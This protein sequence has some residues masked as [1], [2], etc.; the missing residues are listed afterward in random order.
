[1]TRMA[2]AIGSSDSFIQA[3]FLDQPLRLLYRLR[4]GLGLVVL[5]GSIL[6]LL[7]G[8][9][10]IEW[11]TLIGRD[12]TL[13]P[14]HQLMLLG[15]ALSGIAAL[16]SVLIETV[17][18]RRSQEI[19]AN[20][21]SFANFFYAPL[22][23]YLAGFA[24]LSAGI[25]FTLDSYWHALYGIDVAIWAPFHI[26]L[27]GGSGM[28]S[29]GAAYMLISAAH[30]AERVGGASAVVRA[31]YIGATISFAM[32][33]GIVAILLLDAY[34]VLGY[35]SLGFTT[36]NLFSVIAATTGMWI[37]IAAVKAL[38]WRWSASY[39]VIVYMLF[40]VAVILF[41]PPAIK[42]LAQ[43]E[44]LTFRKALRIIPTVAQAWPIGVIYSAI[45]LD[46]LRRRAQLNAWSARKFTLLAALITLP[47]WLPI[48]LLIPYIFI[49][50]WLNAG[51]GGFI[52]SALLG[53]AG[54][55]V[56]IWLG[57][58]TGESLFE[59]ERV[60]AADA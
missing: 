32:M 45:L 48:A 17:F 38:P 46:V 9:W 31:C 35:V 44:Q 27:I 40:V 11:H 21:F 34:G 50:V 3:G 24:A 53:L 54:S 41:V 58:R 47:G 52:L 4:L 51:A 55:F 16:L 29:L 42:Q 15:I 8:S 26:M 39:I 7:G 36:F 10:D 43:D 49:G 37:L 59:Q 2:N 6:F 56:G 18:A 13:I 12:R 5:L 30:L 22:G 25:G 33:L 20:A 60:M 14:P 1:M 19:A 57:Q 23:A 28:A